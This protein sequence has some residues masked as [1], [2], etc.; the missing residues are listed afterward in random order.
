MD[1]LNHTLIV[2]QER[3]EQKE[4]VLDEKEIEILEKDELVEELQEKLTAAE[5]LSATHESKN[6]ELL[7]KL[8][9]GEADTENWRTKLESA[10]KQRPS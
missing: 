3:L 7:A 10:G 4:F 6:A 2:T 1:E 5:K 9:Q 8:E